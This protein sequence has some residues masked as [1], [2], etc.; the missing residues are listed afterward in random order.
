MSKR[1]TPS[2]ESGA[3]SRRRQNW[4]IAFFHIDHPYGHSDFSVALSFEF[5]P[6][7]DDGDVWCDDDLFRAKVFGKQS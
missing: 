7:A 3:K 4:N 6:I 1:S 2:A 5:V